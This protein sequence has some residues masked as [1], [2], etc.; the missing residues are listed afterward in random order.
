MVIYAGEDHEHG[1][2]LSFLGFKVIHSLEPVSIHALIGL[3]KSGQI[4]RI[5]PPNE[6]DPTEFNNSKFTPMSE[7]LHVI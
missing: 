1:E 5:G 4:P 7:L 3:I 2:H 6:N